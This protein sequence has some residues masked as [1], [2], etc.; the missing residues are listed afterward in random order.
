MVLHHIYGAAPHFMVHA[1]W[2]STTFMVRVFWCSTT[3]MVHPLWCSTT[4]MFHALWCCTTF[5]V[6]AYWCSTT[7]MV[8][9]LWCSTT[10]M[11]HAFWCSTTFV[12]HVL[13]CSNTFSFCTSAILEHPVSAT[14]ESMRWNNNMAH[15]FTWLKSFIFLSLVTSAVYC[16]C[17]RS[18]RHPAFATANTKWI[19]DNFCD[20]WNFPANQ[21]I[22]VQTCN[23]L[24]L[25]SRWTLTVFSNHQEAASQKPCFSR[26]TSFS[27][28]CVNSPSVCFVHPVHSMSNDC[29]PL[30]LDFSTV[31]VWQVQQDLLFHTSPNHYTSIYRFYKSVIII[32]Y[33][34][35]V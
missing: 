24:H 34:P 19:S 27:Y 29:R 5:M 7:F 6:H 26:P 16:L 23:V 9:T 30:C 35:T 1:L 3:F 33:V 25:S 18:H 10:F 11:V 15:P 2:C 20:T 28:C 4:L 13:W 32:Q 22:T 12:V 31:T 8:H 17:Y 21:A 14:M